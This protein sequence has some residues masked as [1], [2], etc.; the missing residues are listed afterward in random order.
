MDYTHHV[1]I[2]LNLAKK[3]VNPGSI[4]GTVGLK[5]LRSPSFKP[6]VDRR[7]NTISSDVL[8]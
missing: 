5:L 6:M 8:G 3:G 1:Q 2:E 7:S 4:D